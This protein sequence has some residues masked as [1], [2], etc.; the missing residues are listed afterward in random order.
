LLPE[1]FGGEDGCWNG[2]P[3]PA[4][5]E[6]DVLVVVVEL[7]F[8]P[9][10]VVVEVEDVVVVL[11]PAGGAGGAGGDGGV[12]GVVGVVVGA[13]VVAGGQDSETDLAGPGRFSEDTGA[14]G[15]SWK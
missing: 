11:E 6:D 15:A 3:L 2:C 4:G 14:P 13:G 12:G 9:G 10:G 8:G 7:V 1:E 5:L